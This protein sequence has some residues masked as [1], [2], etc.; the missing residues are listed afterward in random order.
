MIA[1]VENL[2]NPPT[3]TGVSF[4]WMEKIGLEYRWI[5]R[6]L[7]EKISMG[8]MKEKLYFDIIHYAKRQ[9][10]WLRKNKNIIWK[11][12]YNEIEKIVINFLKN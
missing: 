1:E 12:D 10:T 3:G 2:N 7:Q 8:D 9:M 6:F 11:N 4:E 5:S